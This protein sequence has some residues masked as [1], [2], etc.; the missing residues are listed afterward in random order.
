M[1]IFDEF[2]RSIGETPW[3]KDGKSEAFDTLTDWYRQRALQFQKASY[4]TNAEPIEFGFIVS[5][6]LNAFATIQGNTDV[7]A[8][9]S[10]TVTILK[11][12]FGILLSRKEI[13]PSIGNAAIEDSQFLFP[14]EWADDL[15]QMSVQICPWPRDQARGDYAAKLAWIARYFI[16]QH[17]FCHLFN[18]HVDWFSQVTGL[19]AL[20]EVG[21]ASAPYISNL[22][23]QTLEMDADCYAA[24][25]T[26]LAV[27]RV[28][29]EALFEN[30]A[31]LRTYREAVFAICI[32]LYCTFRLF[33]TGEL[34][35]ETDLLA[36][37]HPPAAL[38]QFLWGATIYSRFFDNPAISNFIS[39]E[40]FRAACREALQEA[41]Q[42]F[43]LL[44]WDDRGTV[45]SSELIDSLRRAA[46]KLQHNWE[47]I[48][49]QLEPFKRG[50]KLA[51]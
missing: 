36:G 27:F 22:D 28:T 33:Y 31:H 48:R 16:F 24:S 18:G 38:R 40:D 13:L 47:S 5:T 9:N 26:L 17:E 37:D 15:S 29:P 34:T 7:I 42:A 44:G 32:A 2:A 50:A 8:I 51:Q 19:K 20:G 4:V 39:Q 6:E 14:K 43:K 35:E 30:A 25:H 49:D 3:E 12:L 21:A 10:G 41:T 23:L 1:T 46:D 45:K 11:N